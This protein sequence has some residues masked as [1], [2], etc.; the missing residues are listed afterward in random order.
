MTLLCSVMYKYTGCFGGTGPQ[1]GSSNSHIGLRIFD[2]LGNNDIGLEFVNVFLALNL[3][4]G[5]T[6]AMFME[7]GTVP[8]SRYLLI[9][10]DIIVHIA[11][12]FQ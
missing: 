11:D 8:G 12:S 9:R 1:G 6:F 7:V 5:M 10:N 3:Y 4:T 2:I